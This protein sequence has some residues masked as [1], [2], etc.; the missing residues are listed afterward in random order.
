MTDAAPHFVDR[1]GPSPRPS[2]RGSMSS[3]RRTAVAALHRTTAL[4]VA[5]LLT[6][7]RARAQDTT[8]VEYAVKVV[9]GSPDSAQ[10]APGTYFTAINVYNPSRDTVRFTVRIAATSPGMRP[11]PVSPTFGASLGPGQ[12]LEIDCPSMFARVR[13]R[14]WIKGFA[15]IRSP[16]ELD[17]VAVYSAAGASRLVETRDVAGVPPRRPLGAP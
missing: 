10:A 13:T 11:G 9:C 3:G 4:L 8:G 1:H 7:S 5:V 6:A 12:A 16:G 14:R 2:R 17:V 15:R